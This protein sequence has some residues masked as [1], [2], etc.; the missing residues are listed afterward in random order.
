MADHAAWLVTLGTYAIMFPGK[1]VQ[2]VV[3]A[4]ELETNGIK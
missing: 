2:V 1:N 3:T 4:L